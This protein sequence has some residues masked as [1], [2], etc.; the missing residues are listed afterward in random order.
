MVVVIAMHEPVR[1]RAQRMGA[2]RFRRTLS[3]LVMEWY[4]LRLMTE[5]GYS[6]LY[7]L[8]E[9]DELHD[10]DD[11]IRLPRKAMIGMDWMGRSSCR[12]SRP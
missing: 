12:A 3:S 2:Y 6:T 1:R 5:L 7:L 9:M 4:V 10:A 11:D 8:S